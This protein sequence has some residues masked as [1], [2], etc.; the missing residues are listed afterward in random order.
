MSQETENL[1]VSLCMAL[2]EGQDYCH[3]ILIADCR[4]SWR[5]GILL[6][7]I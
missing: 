2:Q 6:V 7:N 5:G 3:R 4:L 1:L